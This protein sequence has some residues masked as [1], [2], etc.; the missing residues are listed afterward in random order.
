[1]SDQKELE[2]AVEILDKL[3]K[4][5]KQ[6]ISVDSDNIEIARQTQTESPTR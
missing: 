4:D 2:K 3:Y 5:K 6:Q 1:M